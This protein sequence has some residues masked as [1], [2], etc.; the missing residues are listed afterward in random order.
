MINLRFRLTGIDKFRSSLKKFPQQLLKA[1][2]G[3]MNEEAEET[4]SDAKIL[5]PVDQGNLRASGHVQKAVFN[6]LAF[7]IQFGFGGPAAGYAL[8]VHEQ[9]GVFGLIPGGGTRNDSPRA[10]RRHRG[11]RRRRKFVGQAKYL[12][13][14]LDARAPSRMDRVTKRIQARLE[15]AR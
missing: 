10:Y 6:G 7:T 9:V 1:A 3:A 11:K 13:V 15:R 8:F 12:K 14:A 5:T 4:I 2:A